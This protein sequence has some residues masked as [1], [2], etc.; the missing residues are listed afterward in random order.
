M[1]R[2]KMVTFHTLT[3]I[4]KTHSKIVLAIVK[5]WMGGGVGLC[6][7]VVKQ[8]FPY[9][10]AS[11]QLKFKLSIFTNSVFVHQLFAILVL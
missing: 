10:T 4:Y 2:T 8:D 5:N 9:L 6:M 7:S 1:K 3:S 11:C